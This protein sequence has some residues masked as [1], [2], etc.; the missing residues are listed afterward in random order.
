MNDEIANDV[1][2]HEDEP[3]IIDHTDQHIRNVYLNK[4]N[5]AVRYF[6][7]SLISTGLS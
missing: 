4:L 2:A 7:L 3:Q 5:L 1:P 6:P